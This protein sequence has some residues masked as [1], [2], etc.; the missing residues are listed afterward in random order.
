MPQM[1]FFPQ[2]PEVHPM[3]YAYR[4]LNPDYDGLL[5][6][7]YTEKDVDRRVA[8]QYPTKRP[9]GKLPYEILYRSSAMREDG[10]CFTDHDVHRMLRRRKIT[11]V[12]GEWFRCTVDELEAAVLAVKTDT[13]NEENRTRTFVMRP[14]QEE[15]VNKTIAYFRSAKQD[16]PERAPKFLWNAKMRFGKTF[17]AYELA[18][19]MGLKK[20][21]V[22]TFKPAVEAAWEEDLMTHKDFEGWQFICRDGMRYEDADLSRPIVCFGSFQD[23]LGTNESGGIK[24]KNEWVHTTNWDIVI[25]DEYHFGA[26][27]DNAKKLFEMDNE[28]EDYDFD[29]EKYKKDEADNAYNETFLPV[30]TSYYLFLSGTPFRAINSG[31]FIEDQIYNWTYSDE[32]RAKE[33]WDGAADNPYAAL[34]RMV[35]MTYRIPDSIRQIAMQG[36]FDEFDLNVFFSAKYGEKSKPETARFVYENEVQKWLDLIRGSYLPASVDDMKLGQDKRPPMPFSDTRLLSVLSHTFW[37]LP[38]VASCYAMYNLLQ[39][40]QNSFYHDYRINVCA[41][42]K[43][44]IGVDALE[45]VQTSMGD[46]L[47]TKTITLSCGKLTTGVTVKPWTGIFMLRNLKSP[48][49]YFQA[50]FRVQSPWTVRT[51]SG[52]DQIMKYECYVFDFALDRALKQ[53]SDYSCRLNVNESNPEKKVAEFI[54]FLPVLAYDGSSMKQIDAQDILDIAMAGTSATLLAKRWESALLV[55][56]DNDTLRRLMANKE[57]MEALMKIEGF[58]S[59]NSDIETIINKSESVKKAKK[60]KGKELTKE[61][62]KELSEEEKEYKSMRKQI[63]EKLIK[64]ATRVPIFMYLTD[65]RERSLKDVITQLEPGLF[66]KVTGL[67]VKDFNLLVEL[68]VFNASLMND[69]IFKFK[70]YEDSSLSYTGLDK[71]ENEDVGGWDT[72]VKRKEYELLFYNQQSTM[73][74]PEIDEADVPEADEEPEPPKAPV[75][76]RTPPAKPDFVTAAFGVKSPIVPAKPQQPEKPKVD[77]SGVAVGSTVAHAKF[78]IGKVIELNR[79]YVTVRFEQGEKR[80]IFPDAFESGFLKAQ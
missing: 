21:L 49:T 24:A 70:R 41:G 17:A 63:Q 30:T 68:N 60:E 78:G 9:D 55:N 76:T 73:N 54:N 67:D 27:R 18:K 6:V 8:Q 12:G 48:E 28:D 62:K 14:E 45:P 71:H 59:L 40:K 11:G 56:V 31:E 29:M 3:I 57:A 42:T 38:N 61:E 7:G 53:I 13:L 20:V 69:A 72:V 37:F 43:A 58:R 36:Q 35:M 64:F 32:Q 66:K 39:Q 2:R 15:A 79:G 65:Y 4:D 19:R 33:N 50:A 77:V 16:A 47:T 34:P 5:K 22:L 74:A 25:F 26:W 10:S 80:F 23:Y 52:T 75:P 46:P 51:G 1:D 44:G